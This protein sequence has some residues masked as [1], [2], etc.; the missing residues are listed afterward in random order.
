MYIRAE[1]E[2]FER[3]I[4]TPKL[5]V[6]YY[7]ATWNEDCRET[8]EFIEKIASRYSKFITI[9]GVDIDN[10][11]QYK[12]AIKVDRYPTFILFKDG[13]MIDKAEGFVSAIDLDNQIVKYIKHYFNPPSVF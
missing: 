3:I 8:N 1:N 12:K 2:S 5:V 7:Y 4:Q 9:V 10:A 11:V 13:N 6:L